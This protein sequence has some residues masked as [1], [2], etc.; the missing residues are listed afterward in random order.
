MA[1]E[2]PGVRPV[3][4]VLRREVHVELLASANFVAG[5]VV[6]G[7]AHGY[8]MGKTTVHASR[9]AGGVLEPAWASVAIP[10]PSQDGK[11]EF[12]LQYTGG[13]Y[14]LLGYELKPVVNHAPTDVR[15]YKSQS[16]LQTVALETGGTLKSQAGSIAALVATGSPAYYNRATVA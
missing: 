3:I 13:A 11:G 14:T 5:P 1:D 7:L 10:V 16:T 15:R 9:V 12:M 2:F 4:R 6:I 8:E